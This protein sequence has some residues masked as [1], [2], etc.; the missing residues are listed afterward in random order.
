[1]ATIASLRLGPKALFLE[2]RN[3]VDSILE[4]ESLDSNDARSRRLFR[5]VSTSQQ[6]GLLYPQATDRTE[7]KA[8]LRKH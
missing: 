3:D 4:L 6:P 2:A 7:A 1:M 8:T 5:I